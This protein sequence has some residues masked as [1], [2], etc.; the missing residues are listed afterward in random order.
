MA[1]GAG[2]FDD[3][4]ARSNE[5]ER[6]NPEGRCMKRILVIQGHPNPREEHF[7]HALANEYLRSAEE[8]GHEVRSVRVA[9]L[10][11]PLLQDAAD[12][13]EG[14][15]PQAIR[16]VQESIAWADHLVIVFPLW[17]GDMPA[18]LKGFF[19][20]TLRPGFAISKAQPGKLWKKLLKKKSARVI[21]TMGMPA[22]FYRIYY[23]AH[24]VK[25]LKRNILDFCGI[26]PVR[27]TLIGMVESKGKDLHEAWL[28]KIALLGFK[29]T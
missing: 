19:E 3:L 14:E 10:D 9:K 7:C 27:T 18:L 20:Q 12:W 8:A 23:Q 25:S 1:R 24:S 6:R 4:P 17:L 22:F 13:K 2:L 26:S 11:F 5:A 15:P 21:V 29:A 28:A 16:K